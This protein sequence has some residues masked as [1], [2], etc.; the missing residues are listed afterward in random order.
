MKRTLL[1]S[2]S[3]AIAL[4]MTGWAADEGKADATAAQKA[5][6]FRLAPSSGPLLGEATDAPK[7]PHFAISINAKLQRKGQG[8]P[9]ATE[10]PRLWWTGD[11]MTPLERSRFVIPRSDRVRE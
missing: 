10:A 3:A 1:A 4:A 5:W 8:E 7:A 9:L 11:F 2:V 6:N